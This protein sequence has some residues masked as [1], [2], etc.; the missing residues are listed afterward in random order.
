VDAIHGAIQPLGGF[1]D[2]RS[3]ADLLQE[4]PLV[5]FPHVAMTL[6]VG[7]AMSDEF[8]AARLQCVDDTGRIVENRRVDQVSRREVQFIE[9]FEAAPNAN[10]VAVIAPGEGPGVWSRSCYGQEMTFARAER[11]VFD[12][13][14]EIYR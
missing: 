9:Q 10:P 14:A 6:R 3:I 5:S 1:P 8:I 7:A 4:S 2:A 13:E 11:E 12:V